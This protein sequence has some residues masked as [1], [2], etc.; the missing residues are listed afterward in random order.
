MVA[1]HIYFYLGKNREDDCQK[2]QPVCGD[3]SPPVMATQARYPS[4]QREL[5]LAGTRVRLCVRSATGPRSEAPKRMRASRLGAS[6]L[7]QERTMLHDQKT[8]ERFGAKRHT[9]DSK[10]SPTCAA[11]LLQPGADECCAIRKLSSGLERSDIKKR[12]PACAG[13]QGLRGRGTV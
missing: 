10:A 13:R 9:K 5:R 4:D 3:Y 6:L 1:P 7:H 8:I 12:R 11:S 2:G